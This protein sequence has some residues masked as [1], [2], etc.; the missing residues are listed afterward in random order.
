MTLEV[1]VCPDFCTQFWLILRRYFLVTVLSG[2]Q[3]VTEEFEIV[4]RPEQ[5][6]RFACLNIDLAKVSLVPADKS[7]SAHLAAL[8]VDVDCSSLLGNQGHPIGLARAVSPDREAVSAAPFQGA[9]SLA[10][11]VLGCHNPISNHRLLGIEGPIFPDLC[12]V[13]DHVGVRASLD[14]E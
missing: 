4:C 5:Q 10:P 3:F 6:P 2:G 9:E 8:L 1:Q 13:V 11:A 7:H 12:V 14:D